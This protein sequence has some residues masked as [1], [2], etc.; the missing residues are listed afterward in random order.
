MN[1]LQPTPIGGL[2]GPTGGAVLQFEQNGLAGV[3]GEI[4][5]DRLPF[6]GDDVFG[7]RLLAIDEYHQFPV[8]LGMIGHF[9]IERGAFAGRHID[10]AGQH[11]G[12]GLAARV[13]E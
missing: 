4:N 10:L 2:V 6:R 3:L 1:Q 11:T 7:Q 8:T 5:L 13:C 12:L 9:E